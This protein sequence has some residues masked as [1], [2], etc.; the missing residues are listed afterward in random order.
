MANIQVTHV[1][2]LNNARSESAIAI[3]PNN[4][5]QIVAG[6]K[7]FRN[8]ETYD[9][10][11][12]T[13]FSQDGGLTWQDSAPLPLSGFTVLS[14]PTIAWD[15][16]GNVYLLGLSAND[17]P[18][19]NLVGIEGYKSTDGGQTWTGP[20]HVHASSVDDKQWVAGDSNTASPFHGR[21]YG[22]WDG[23]QRPLLRPHQR[24]RSDLGGRR[25]GKH[26]DRDGT[27]AEFLRA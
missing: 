23:P 27:G 4:P 18:A 8:L 24:R 7:F 9:F 17:P 2:D 13:Q 1:T 25:R 11:L 15:D 16:V 3:N 26:S 19:D 12:A 14:D 5:Q 20:T 21:I 22:A 6:S 10:T